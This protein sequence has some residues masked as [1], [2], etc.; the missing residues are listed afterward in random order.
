MKS[1]HRLLAIFLI[2]L[3]VSVVYYVIQNGLLTN[4]LA[5]LGFK[6]AKPAATPVSPYAGSVRLYFISAKSI[7]DNNNYVS[8]KAFLPKDSYVDVSGW[9]LKTG[10]GVYLI[11]QAVDFNTAPGVMGDIYLKNGSIL[12]VYSGKSPVGLNGRTG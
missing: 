5:A 10:L 3:V 11:P 12:T 2:L 6:P 9:R 4:S 8:I 1:H 7:A